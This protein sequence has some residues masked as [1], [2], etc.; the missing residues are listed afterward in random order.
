MKP[1][2]T[3]DSKGS[4]RKTKFGENMKGLNSGSKQ[5]PPKR[6]K[7]GIDIAGCKAYPE[8]KY[9]GHKRRYIPS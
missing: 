1:M 6:G 9:S 8:D 7:A 5:Y 2:M 4:Y 3:K